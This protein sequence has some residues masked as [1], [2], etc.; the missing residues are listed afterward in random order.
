LLFYN[1]LKVIKLGIYIKEKMKK[2]NTRLYRE[3]YYFSPNLYHLHVVKDIFLKNLGYNFRDINQN[4]FLH[5]NNTKNIFEKNAYYLHFLIIFKTPEEVNK[6]LKK[7]LDD[8]GAYATKMFVNYPLVC[9]IDKN[10]I[11]PLMCCMLWCNNRN[12]IRELYAWGADI[13]IGD[14]NGRYPE[15]LYG[16]FSNY[17]NHLSSY[18]AHKILFFGFRVQGDFKNVIEEMLFLS[19]KK[20]TPLNWKKPRRIIAY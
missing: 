16:P 19:D 10:I 1:V 2:G 11:T 12:M 5:N 9:L 7:H 15:E 14:I 20:E 17:T 18:I 13:S 4:F 6:F 3:G 8:Y